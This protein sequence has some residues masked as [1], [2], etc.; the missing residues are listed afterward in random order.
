[1]KKLYKISYYIK[2]DVF[3]SEK[4]ELLAVKF[5]RKIKS[6]PEDVFLKVEKL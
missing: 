1:M 6:L 2:K 4:S 3:V 5:V